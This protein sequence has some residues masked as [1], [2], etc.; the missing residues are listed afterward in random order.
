[1]ERIVI[2]LTP[3]SFNFKFLDSKYVVAE[4]EIV[5]FQQRQLL[6]LKNKSKH[7][8]L[9]A[10][11]AIEFWK[12]RRR[13]QKGGGKEAAILWCFNW[14]RSDGGGASVDG[15]VMAVSSAAAMVMANSA[16]RRSVDGSAQ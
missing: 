12:R 3:I 9:D 8:Q 13:Q 7:S 4:W 11:C 2:L 1:M 10:S 16:A 6:D 14:R 15:G 5:R